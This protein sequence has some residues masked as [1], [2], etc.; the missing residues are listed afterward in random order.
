MD[1]TPK[2]FLSAL[3][4]I[5]AIAPLTACRTRVNDAKVPRI[6]VQDT[7]RRLERRPEK[8]LV[9]DVRDPE[10]FGQGRLPGA[11]LVSLPDVDPFEPT[12]Q[13][14]GFGMIIVYGQNPGAGPAM[15]L[16]KR[17]IQAR[18]EDVNL[19]EAGFDSWKAM[20]YPVETD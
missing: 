19:M 12:P 15:A 9:L 8:T 13:F 6:T 7:A 4:L 10:R 14:S 5:I 11:E 17:L 20:G 3:A 1:A 16:A 18:H 2:R